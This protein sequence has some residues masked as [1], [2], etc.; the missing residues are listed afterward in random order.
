V[1][2][3]RGF[4]VHF[5]LKDIWVLQYVLSLLQDVARGPHPVVA[6]SFEKYELYSEYT[7]EHNS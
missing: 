6:F 5:T 2:T 4:V 3:L 1:L 7:Q